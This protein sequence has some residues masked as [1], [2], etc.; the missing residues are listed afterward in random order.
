MGDVDWLYVTLCGPLAVCCEQGM[1]LRFPK[2]E[3]DYFT[4]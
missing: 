2:T 4:S 3:A 1:D